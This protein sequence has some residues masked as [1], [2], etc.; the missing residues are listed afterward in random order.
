MSTLHERLSAVEY[1]DEMEGIDCVSML[2]LLRCTSIRA[3]SMED[4]YV[5]VSKRPSFLQEFAGV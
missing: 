4:Y 1:L 2:L 3:Q 5:S